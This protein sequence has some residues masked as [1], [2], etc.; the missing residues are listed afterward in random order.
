MHDGHPANM[1]QGWLHLVDCP[2]VLVDIRSFFHRHYLP[3]LGISICFMG[4][5]TRYN[6]GYIWKTQGYQM[7]LW[8]RNRP[9][10]FNRLFMYKHVT[11]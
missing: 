4:D 9:G 2:C 3:C 7:I 10:F 8:H 5:I 1:V 11:I 6:G